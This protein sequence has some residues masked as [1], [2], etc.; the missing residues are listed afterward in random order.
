MLTSHDLGGVSTLSI[1]DARGRREAAA[2]ERRRRREEAAARTRGSRGQVEV[3][4]NRTGLI[5]P[6]AAVMAAVGGD[7][8]ALADFDRRVEEAQDLPNG[9][10]KTRVLQALKAELGRLEVAGT[11]SRTPGVGPVHVGAPTRTNPSASSWIARWATVRQL[12]AGLEKELRLKALMQEK[13]G[14]S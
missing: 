9:E 4:A 3:P 1:G 6:N 12:P 10:A 7:H 8:D 11:S 2:E 5:L 14:A 13:A